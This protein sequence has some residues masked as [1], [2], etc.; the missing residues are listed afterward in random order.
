MSYKDL[1]T[2]ADGD[3]VFINGDVKIDE[4]DTQHVE[5]ILIAD[6]GQFRQF[7]LIGV[8]I[9][10][11]QNGSINKQALKQ[12]VKLQLES[13]GYNVRQIVVE[14]NENLKIEVDADRKNV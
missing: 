10:R 9:L 7:P 5:H 8:G 6:K 14:T 2:D 12:S 11:F 13:D 3:L 1:I 4:S